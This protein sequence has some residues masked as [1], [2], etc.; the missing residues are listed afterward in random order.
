MRREETLGATRA[1][2]RKRYILGNYIQ[3]M[4]DPFNVVFTQKIP[5]NSLIQD[6]NEC[7]QSMQHVLFSVLNTLVPFWEPRLTFTVSMTL[8]GNFGTV[9]CPTL[10]WISMSGTFTVFRGTSEF[11]TRAADSILR[12]YWQLHESRVIVLWAFFTSTPANRS[13]FVTSAEV[14]CNDSYQ[15]ILSL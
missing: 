9:R 8:W 3:N 13:G 1:I 6:I 2:W 15:S 4:F 14:D 7:S 11:S 5:H 12:V 10:L